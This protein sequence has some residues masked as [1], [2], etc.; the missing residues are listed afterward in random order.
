MVGDEKQRHSYY[1]WIP[2]YLIIL[3]FLFW[4]PKLIWDMFEDGKMKS[5][6]NGVTSGGTHDDQQVEKIG[7][8]IKSYIE[9]KNAGH[10]KYGFGYL[11]TCVSN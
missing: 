8:S 6:T 10:M 7:N 5:I 1:Q 4:I 2:Y 11:L 9:S 3:A